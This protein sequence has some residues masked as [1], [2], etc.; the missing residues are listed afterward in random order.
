MA[1]RQFADIVAIAALVAATSLF[2]ILVVN[3]SIPPFED[4]AML[5]RYAGHM[6]QGEGIVWNVGEAPVDGATDFLFM[7]SVALVHYIGASLEVAVRLLTITSHFATVLLIYWGMRK[8]QGAGITIAFLSAAYFAV[9]PGLFLSAAYF[10]TSFFALI[11]TLAWLLGQRLIFQEK[12]TVAGYVSFSLACLTAGLVRPEGVLISVFMLLAIGVLIP[13]KQFWQLTIVFASV[14][15]LIGGSYFAWRWHYFGY[16]LPNPFYVKGGGHLYFGSLETSLGNT[17]QLIYP[18]IPAFLFSAHPR[19]NPR[20]GL[21]LAIPIVGAV[22]MWVLLSAE[23]NFGGRFQYPILAICLLSW[24]PLVKNL[25]SDMG[26]PDFSS[27]SRKK[28][29]A[30]VLSGITVLALVY[31][32]LVAQSLAI[33]YA[34]DGRYDVGIMLSD[35]KERGYTL[36]TTEAGLVPL[37]SGWRAVDTWGLNDQWIAHNGGVTE[38]YLKRQNPDIILWHE[39]FSPQH[40]PSPDREGPWFR[41]VMVLKRYAE[42]HDYTLAAVFGVKPDDTHYYYVRSRLADHDEIVRRIRGLSYAWIENGQICK[43]Y[44]DDPLTHKVRSNTGA[45]TPAVADSLSE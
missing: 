42:S 15:L 40:P 4:A 38:E 37:Y 45:S 19:G 25:R 12:Y 35:Y 26:L 7:V 5:M 1:K 18:F 11:L 3:F 29:G 31:G 6:A 2:A 14:F 20:M 44:A 39:Y 32:I 24:F 17:L 41:Q 21:A 27:L 36:A 16:P 22:S 9:G 43:N 28:K 34:R 13:R 8:I 10:G 30:I 23:M 33:T